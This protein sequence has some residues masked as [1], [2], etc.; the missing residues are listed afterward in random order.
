MI[1][2]SVNNSYIKAIKYLVRVIRNCN[3]SKY[4]FK[5]L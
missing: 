2:I 1:A 4:P 5:Y 3:T